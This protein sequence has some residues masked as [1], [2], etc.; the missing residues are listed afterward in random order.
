[1]EM[2]RRIATA[3]QKKIKNLDLAKI[4]E[5]QHNTVK[6]N[7]LRA[8]VF[9]IIMYRC[10]AQTP[11]KPDLDKLTAFEMK[12]HRNCSKYQGQKKITNEETLFKAR[13]R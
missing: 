5:G 13:K 12:C 10:E 4:W 3:S 1:M 11:L 7:I 6:V 9:P 2:V 8:C